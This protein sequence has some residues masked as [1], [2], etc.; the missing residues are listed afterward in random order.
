MRA[1][2]SVINAAG[3]LKKSLTNQ[4]EE[5]ILLRA[6][7]DVNI[8]KFLSFDI[9]LFENIIEDLFPNIKKPQYNYSILN[10]AVNEVIENF[11][12]HLNDYFREKVYQLHDII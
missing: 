8:S 3:Y 10:K 2:T 4:E 11:N 7:K 9:P 5:Q 12:L 6:L 1:V